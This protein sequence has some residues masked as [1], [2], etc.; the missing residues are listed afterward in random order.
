MAAYDGTTFDYVI[1]VTYTDADGN[2]ASA[3]IN[4][5]IGQRGDANCD[6]KVNARD[7]AAIARDL[8]QLYATK[9]TTL[10]AEDGF[11]IFLGNSDESVAKKVT[12]HYGTFDLNVRDA[13]NLAKFLANVYVDKDL[14]LKDVVGK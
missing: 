13:A 6:H 3:E 4:A 2:T 8:S 12:E 11:G 10:T 9:K 1:T 7:A 5:K 14:T